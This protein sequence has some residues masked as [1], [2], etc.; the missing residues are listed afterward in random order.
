MC[1]SCGSNSGPLACEMETLPTELLCRTQA[2]VKFLDWP[3]KR[4]DFESDWTTL[5]LTE[6]KAQETGSEPHIRT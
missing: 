6:A 1:R 2:H 3:A 4:P 5:E